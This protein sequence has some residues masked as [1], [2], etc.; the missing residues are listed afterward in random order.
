ML[1]RTRS[2]RQHLLDW[3]TVSDIN[4]A[5]YSS[6]LAAQLAESEGK[7]DMVLQHYEQAQD[8]SE[9]HSLVTDQALASEL[10]AEFMIRRGVRRPA[11]ASLRDA[12]AL[13]RRVS[14]FGKA[15]YLASKHEWL[16]KVYKTQAQST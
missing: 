16:L 9:L 4:F 11:R 5:V 12:I 14:A 3:S 10:Y 8:H 1:Q 2:Y 13:Y 15:E 7:Y 6:L